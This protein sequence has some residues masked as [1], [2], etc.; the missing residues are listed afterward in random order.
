[1]P[2]FIY[3][4]SAHRQLS[5]VTSFESYKEARE[6]ARNMRAQALPEDQDTVKIVYAKNPEEAARML[7]AKRERQPS[8]DD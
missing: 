1:M 5:M 2:Y 7:S 3:R 6:M 4:I 8:E